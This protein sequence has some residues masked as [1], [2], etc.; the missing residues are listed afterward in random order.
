MASDQPI[1]ERKYARKALVLVVDDDPLHRRLIELVSEQLHITAHVASSCVEAMDALRMFVFDIILMDIRM[2]EI[3]GHSCTQH[4]RSLS[5]KTSLIPIIAVTGNDSVA[6]R[7]KCAEVGMDDF[8]RKPFTVEE[9]C[10]KISFWLSQM[11]E[12]AEA[13]A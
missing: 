6:N 4:I 2:P 1:T 10:A 5:E 9:L 8:L 12:C 7:L 13:S 3:D 11:E